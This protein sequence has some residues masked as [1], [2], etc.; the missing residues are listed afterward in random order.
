[1]DT[2]TL[3][4]EY[5]K[6]T[7][8]PRHLIV[9]ENQLDEYDLNNVFLKLI[10]LDISAADLVDMKKQLM[11]DHAILT[12]EFASPPSSE[13]EE[14]KQHIEDIKNIL[15]QEQDEMLAQYAKA[16]GHGDLEYDRLIKIGVE[17]CQ[18]SQME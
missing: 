5:I 16:V 17:L 14:T 6:N 3:E 12:F 7:F 9:K 11:E 1:M 4:T 10:P 8:S 2:E 13:D 18:Q 15:A